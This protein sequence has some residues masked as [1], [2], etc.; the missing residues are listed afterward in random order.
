MVN[1]HFLR[2]FK[3]NHSNLYSLLVSLLLAVWY[4]GISGV[5]NLWFP[6]RGIGISMLMLVLPLVIFLLDDGNLDELYK[7]PSST[8]PAIASTVASPSDQSELEKFDNR[9]RKFYY[10]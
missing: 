8:Y 5:I 2:N 10:Y 7:Q 1:F 9:I 4:N 3:K 6:Q